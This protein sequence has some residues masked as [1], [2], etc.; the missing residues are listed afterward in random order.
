MIHFENSVTFF[1]F[2]RFII[3][4]CLRAFE[5]INLQPRT[6]GVEGTYRTLNSYSISSRS[7]QLS[8]KFLSLQAY[9]KKFAEFPF[10]SILDSL[11]KLKT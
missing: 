7:K 4:F 2:L 8:K 3:L 6:T 10:L 9:E 5:S 11:I 1:G